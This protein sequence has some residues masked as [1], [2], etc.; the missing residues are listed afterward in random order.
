MEKGFKNLLRPGLAI[1]C[2]FWSPPGSLWS[3]E[4]HF[5]R[6]RHLQNAKPWGSMAGHGEI[7][8][9]GTGPANQFSP[10]FPRQVP[11][12]RANTVHGRHIPTS[13]TCELGGKEPPWPWC[14]SSSP[15]HSKRGI[16]TGSRG[17]VR[18]R[19]TP[20]SRSTAH[21]AHSTAE[22]TWRCRSS[23]DGSAQLLLVASQWGPTPWGCLS[24]R[25]APALFL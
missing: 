14:A 23:S 17:G 16:S 8:G 10:Y 21:T 6:K 5:S 1:S 12:L 22:G 7:G 4:Q 18:R 11:H 25:R 19:D 15:A 24:P 13:N 3:L 20:R 2:H 9:P